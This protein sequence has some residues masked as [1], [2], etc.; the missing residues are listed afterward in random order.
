MRQ[1]GRAGFIG[2]GRGGKGIAGFAGPGSGNA[3]IRRPSREKL[4][5]I[6]L[7]SQARGPDSQARDTDS[8]AH[9]PDSQAD[10]LDSQTR[11]PDLQ[12]QW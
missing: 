11:R 12:C 3:G 5:G 1:K 7:D 2:P 6:R 8:Q 9:G 4:F 10:A